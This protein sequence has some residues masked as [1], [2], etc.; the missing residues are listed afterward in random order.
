MLILSVAY[1][2]IA[3]LASAESSSTSNKVDGKNNAKSHNSKSQNSNQKDQKLG[4]LKQQINQQQAKVN[5]QLK[6][7]HSLQNEMNNL[8]K[9]IKRNDLQLDNVRSKLSA[10]LKKTQELKQKYNNLLFELEKQQANLT[11]TV[12]A[13]YRS[14]VNSS[15]MEKLLSSNTQ[16]NLLTKQYLAR[17][18]EQ[19]Q[20]SLAKIQSTTAAITT[21]EK[22]LMDKNQQIE[23][24]ENELREI[25]RQQSANKLQYQRNLKEL[26]SQL[27]IDKRKLEELIANENAL[28]NQVKIATQEEPS[29][30][31]G[32]EP[33]TS[34]TNLGSPK[35]QFNPPVKILAVL[36][37]FNS[38]QMGELRWRGVVLSAIAGSD[39]RAIQGGK[40]AF[41][42]KLQ[43][44]GLIVIIKH[45]KHDLSLYGYNQSLKVK[46]G[47]MVKAGQTIAQVGQ[48]KGR[49]QSGL[50]FEISRR[51]EPVNPL[52]WLKKR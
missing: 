25:Q 40:V 20:K 50:Y 21:Q 47:Q 45:G 24:Q 51:G 15:F 37:K 29:P 27:E 31:I 49:S 38:I 16:Q 36:N 42:G 8:Q 52:R 14:E 5:A 39:V 26:Q 17:L 43:G 32:E 44:Y 2:A 3:P 13:I 10:N 34:G 33:P 48:I 6:T 35:N 41:A 7:K 30:T 23:Q 1:L 18:Y 28:R 19:R 9:Q 22:L 46:R 12:N 11:E 4:E